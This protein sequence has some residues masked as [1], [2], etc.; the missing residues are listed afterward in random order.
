MAQASPLKSGPS[1]AKNSENHSPPPYIPT[2]AEKAAMLVPKLNFTKVF[3]QQ[4][5]IQE[6]EA[7]QKAEEEAKKKQQ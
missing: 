2:S 4:K 1:T 6:H 7:K 5:L 3:E